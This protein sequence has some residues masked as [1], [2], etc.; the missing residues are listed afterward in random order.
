[1]A[2][3]NYHLKKKS[4]GVMPVTPKAE[5]FPHDAA[6]PDFKA[7][8]GFSTDP[9]LDVIKRSTNLCLLFPNAK[10]DEVADAVRKQ[11][12]GCSRTPIIGLAR[13]FKQVASGGG[14][15]F[16]P[17]SKSGCA[18][19]NG[20][21]A[22][23]EESSRQCDGRHWMHGLKSTTPQARSRLQESCTIPAARDHEN[24]WHIHCKQ[25]WRVDA[26]KW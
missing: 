11:Q 21:P 19:V 26:R 6:A 14:K 10:N 16:G 18:A 8:N 25:C 3:G 17:A 1:M 22:P 12:S 24:E 4:P 13:F 23:R 20:N 5:M 2:R 9:D 15:V 7:H